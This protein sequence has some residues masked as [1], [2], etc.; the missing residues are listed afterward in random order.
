MTKI[1]VYIFELQR[2]FIVLRHL[3]TF[4]TLGT[5]LTVC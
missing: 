4:S 2:V 3:Q 1:V 5:E